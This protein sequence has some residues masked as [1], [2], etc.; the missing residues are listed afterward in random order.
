MSVNLED[1]I[2]INSLYDIYKGLLTE[3][4]RNYFEYYFLQDYS[5][6]E[7]AEILEVSRNAVHMQ[8]KNVVKNLENFETN[9]KILANNHKRRK[10]IE[11]L[12][13]NLTDKELLAILSELEKV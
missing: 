12:K 11:E 1:K 3:K 8:L 5:L 4:Q 13:Q 6:S 2:R 7:I 10:Y 9:L